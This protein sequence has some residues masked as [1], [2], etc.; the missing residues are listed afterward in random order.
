MHLVVIFVDLILGG[1]GCVRI[2][3]VS[4]QDFATFTIKI[5]GTSV[6]VKPSK[7]SSRVTY[8]SC[9]NFSYYRC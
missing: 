8:S 9:K 6:L 7:Q 2:P 1:H 4:R 5:L 3:V